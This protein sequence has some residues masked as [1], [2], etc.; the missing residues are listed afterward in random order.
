MKIFLIAVAAT[1]LVGLTPP[2]KHVI[3]LQQA[4][5]AK[6]IDNIVTGTGNFKGKDV[7]RIKVLDTD[8]NDAFI[9]IPAGTL[10]KSLEE[11]EQNIIVLEEQIVAL[12]D[13]TIFVKGFCSQKK[14]SVLKKESLLA[15]KKN[16]NELLD[17]L[18]TFIAEKPYTDEAL[19][20]A[21]W[22]ITNGASVATIVAY[23]SYENKKLRE[24]ICEL[25]GQENVWYD[26]E[27]DLS[28][29]SDMQIVSTP[30]SVSGKV[31]YT[32]PGK[33][34]IRFSIL[35]E[36]G[37]ILSKGIERELPGKGDYTFDFKAEVTG[38]SIGKYLVAVL[39]NDE[40]IYQK[41]FEIS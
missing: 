7:I 23:K 28:V 32:V 31:E 24:F 20:S 22:V 12:N 35:S 21:V 4:I 37:N 27:R 34:K 25:T 5:E 1:F 39:I 14:N 16:E 17:K 8:N 9:R 13:T 3:S 18:I 19:Q 26:Y 40:V 11:S 41:G 36:D 2:N 30:V 33:G 29:D 6:I 15:I 10:F 38:W